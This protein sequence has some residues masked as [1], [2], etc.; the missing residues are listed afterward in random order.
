ME[1]NANETL[2]RTFI[3][4]RNDQEQ[5]MNNANN[6][7]F[8]G[9]GQKQSERSLELKNSAKE[10]SPRVGLESSKIVRQCREV[11]ATTI[12]PLIDNLFDALDDD[13]YRMAENSNNESQISYFDAMRVLRLFRPG[14]EKAYL[15]SLLYNFDTFWRS[16]GKASYIQKTGED[17]GLKDELSLVGEEELEEELASSGMISKASNRFHRVLF[18]LNKRFA[19]LLG[20]ENVDEESN[21]VGPSAMVQLFR[22]E[23][24]AWDG[25]IVI[26]IVIF[27]LFDKHV[28]GQLK[29]LYDGIN[30]QLVSAAVLP[31]L[32]KWGIPRANSTQIAP[33]SVPTGLPT[34]SPEGEMGASLADS[35]ATAMPTQPTAEGM[36]VPMPGFAELWGVMQQMMAIQKNELGLFRNVVVNVEALPELPHKNVV[37]EL[38]ALQQQALTMPTSSEINLEVAQDDLRNELALRLG[39]IRG[40]IQ[41]Q[42]L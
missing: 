5:T 6:V 7:V 15:S 1:R 18:A 12:A 16:G 38:N 33:N 2:C 14:M 39:K 42:R 13:L 10:R 36:P 35:P 22:R 31:N 9:N 19:M 4:D 20:S 41:T 29:T 11:V 30:Q 21:P 40:G 34:S 23:I 8:L 25:D 28:I 3:V 32:Q 26:R 17:R 37:E 24:C 27:K